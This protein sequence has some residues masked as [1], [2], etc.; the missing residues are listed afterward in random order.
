LWLA[1][2]GDWS[3][4]TLQTLDQHGVGWRSRLQVQSA[5]YDTTGQQRD[6]LAL[7]EAPSGETVDLAVAF[8]EAHRLPARLL[9][10]RV[11]QAVADERRRRLRAVARKK[12][13]MVSARRWA[14]AAWTLLVT[15][16]SSDRWTV[17]EA[18][19]LGRAR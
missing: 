4:E 19:M 5:L 18:L 9:A 15:N 13:R 6:R 7:L 1:D 3:L 8:G 11:P 2:V 12:G 10:V 16:V 17:R 14:L